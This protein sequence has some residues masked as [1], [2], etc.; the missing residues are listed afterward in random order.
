MKIVEKLEQ[1]LN[2]QLATLTQQIRTAENDLLTLKEGY[3]KVSG[4]LEILEIIK[5]EE[6]T[7]AA[8]SDA[9]LFEDLK[10]D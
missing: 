2:N 5:K 1:G 9:I 10:V 7:A 4:A 8:E 6:A 3:L